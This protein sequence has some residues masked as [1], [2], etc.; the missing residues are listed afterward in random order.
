[1][2]MSAERTAASERAR[3]NAVDQPHVLVLFGAR[4]DLA[5][6]M[7]LPGLARLS[8]AGLLPDRFRVIGSGRHQPDREWA[9][10]VADTLEHPDEQ[11]LSEL[12]FVASS[13]E[14]FADLTEAIRSARTEL[15]G[16]TRVLHYLSV[17][18]TAAE[19]IV[20]AIGEAGLHEDAALLLEKPF[21]FDLGSARRLN[22]VVHEHFDERSVFRID[23]FLGKEAA[24][25]IVA[26]RFAN[27]L[28]EPIW[29]REHVAAVF[30]DVPEEI[31]LEGRGSF[32]EEVGALRDMVVTHLC[33]LLGVIAMERPD[34]LEPEPFRDAK[35]EALQALQPFEDVVYGQFDGYREEDDVAQES[36]TETFVAVR[37]KVETD[38]WRGVPFLLRT[39]KEMAEGRKLI[40]LVL[41]GQRASSLF[42]GG[43]RRADEIAIELSD[44]PQIGIRVRVKRPGPDL[45]LIRASLTLDVDRAT[46][47]QSLSAYERLLL[48][49]MRGDQLLFTRA[50][51]VERLWEV[52]ADVI[53]KPPEPQPY[54][55]GSWGPADAVDLARPHRW[56]LG[57]ED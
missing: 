6:R 13:D 43:D 55:R 39:G 44:D 3:T 36:T 24:L 11:F 46:G 19:G 4:G 33:Q 35:L 49:A 34:A 57:D 2:A 38:R 50:D 54:E 26:L 21:G 10:E 47:A 9:Q 42:D 40:S 20:N 15:G 31:G 53:D 18:P 27:D 12:S 29:N 8:R 17:P 37:A 25:D 14:D 28:F 41:R 32:Y 1:M 22:A 48:D 45:E 7:L 30:V 5:K 52:V 23:H 56:P 51:E 16:D